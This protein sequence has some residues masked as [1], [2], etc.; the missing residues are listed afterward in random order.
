MIVAAFGVWHAMGRCRSFP[1]P[2]SG[3]MAAL[4]ASYR[5]GGQS[6]TADFLPCCSGAHGTKQPHTTAAHAAPD[7]RVEAGPG[8]YHLRIARVMPDCGMNDRGAQP[9]S[10]PLRKRDKPMQN[11]AGTGPQQECCHDRQ[12]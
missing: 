12:N 11:A 7:R 5:L 10:G 2:A 9:P 6:A 8:Q 3:L 4:A 1:A